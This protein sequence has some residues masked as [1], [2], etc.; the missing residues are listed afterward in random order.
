IVKL[1][2]LP[3]GNPVMN[4]IWRNGFRAN[5]EDYQPCRFP[6][7]RT[8]YG[9]LFSKTGQHLQAYSKSESGDRS[10][11]S[12]IG[13]VGRKFSQISLQV[14]SVGRGQAA[15]CL[16]ARSFTLLDPAHLP[17]RKSLDLRL[18]QPH[19]QTQFCDCCVCQL[20]LAHFDAL[21]WPPASLPLLR[22]IPVIS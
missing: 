22:S 7:K 19:A 6:S 14:H 15:E 2:W 16:I 10:L 11:K 21:I 8:G 13:G 17:F 3:K 20:D 12:R 18:L 4:R 1:G 9:F 5:T